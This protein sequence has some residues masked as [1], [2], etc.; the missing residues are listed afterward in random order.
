MKSR[1]KKIKFV[2]LV[3]LGICSL[4]SASMSISGVGDLPG[5]AFTFSR[6]HGGSGDGYTVVGYSFGESGGEAFHWTSS[7]GMVG[8]GDL[9]GGSF[10]SQSHGISGD[11]STVVGQGSSASGPEAFLWTQSGGMVGLGDLSGGSFSSTA[12]GISANGSTVVGSGISASSPS[13]FK[14]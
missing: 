9:A 4:A 7:G 3:G 11:G 12:R 5:G 1:Q 13:G 8:L 10:S 14:K 6:A 2:V